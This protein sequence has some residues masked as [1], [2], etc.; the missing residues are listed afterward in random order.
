MKFVSM[1]NTLSPYSL[2]KIS[3]LTFDTFIKLFSILS[4][5]LFG[6]LLLMSISTD[7]TSLKYITSQRIETDKYTTF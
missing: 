3:S 4:Y 1:R 2:F 5:M 6:D 7:Q